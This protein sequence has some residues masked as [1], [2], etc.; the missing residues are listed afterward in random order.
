MR[1]GVAFWVWAIAAVTVQAVSVNDAFEKDWVQYSYGALKKTELLSHQHLL[2][3]STRNL[4]YFILASSRQV[5]AFVDLNLHDSNDF[6]ICG[7][8]IVTFSTQN[9]RLSLFDSSGIYISSIK[10]SAK[11][12]QIELHNDTLLILQQ[13][14]TLTAWNGYQVHDCGTYKASQLKLLPATDYTYFA[15]GS[16]TFR[17]R[18]YENK[19]EFSDLNQ[20]ESKSLFETEH[21][22][23]LINLPHRPLI[24]D[25]KYSVEVNL[26]GISL[27]ELGDKDKT[28]IYSDKLGSVSRLTTSGLAIVVSTPSSLIRYDLLKFASTGNQ[29]D[30]IKKEIQLTDLPDNFIF[31]STQLTESHVGSEIELRTHD[32]QTGSIISSLIPR[33]SFTSSGKAIIV[34][35]QPAVLEERIKQE[36]LMWNGLF[37]RLFIRYKN[38]LVALGRITSCLWNRKGCI[39][40]TVFH[41]DAGFEKLVIFIDDSS[42]DVVA[43]NSL[44]GAIHWTK[45]QTPKESLVGLI[46]VQEKVHVVY[47]HTVLTLSAVDGALLWTESV[48]DSIKKVFTIQQEDSQQEPGTSSIVLWT[49]KGLTFLQNSPKPE[50]PFYLATM[51]TNSITGH[52]VQNSTSRKTWTYAVE[53]GSIIA[54]SKNNDRLTVAGGIGRFDRSVLY[55][56]LDPNI[57]SVISEHTGG[58]KLT[59][60]N[61][62]T[63]E[64]IFQQTHTTDAIDPSS[65]K[66]IS[67]DN[68]VVYSYV[69][70]DLP[71]EQ[72]LVVVD[73][74]Q[75]EKFS[76]EQRSTFEQTTV[77]ASSASFIY[78]ERIHAL[79]ATDTL[80]GITIRSI[81]LL[82][83]SGSLVEVPK[84]VLNSRRKAR[85]DMTKNDYLDDFKMHPYEP[86]ILKTT[87]QV[88][89]H[90]HQLRLADGEQSILVQPTEYE[91][92]T[93]VCFTNELNQFCTIAQP[94]L[95]FD[96][97]ESGF[98]KLQLCATIVI[99]FVAYMFTVPLVY[100]KKLSALWSV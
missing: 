83:E 18:F 26:G 98:Q 4:L 53:H 91:S 45:T 63:G 79:A 61:G 66:L 52:Y 11:P 89:N 84:F 21:L 69:T 65:V 1:L 62:V 22:D 27:F 58:I 82:T 42:G 60:L 50:K 23:R 95:S 100:N 36:E 10:V 17:F 71:F 57:I 49:D 40:D 67:T 77:T 96:S 33:D 3:L 35:K 44:S 41:D 34:D 16:S 46:S 64:V 8:R 90:K 85:S 24:I 59:I 73:L 88:L 76:G 72:R 99:L 15:V 7:D 32:L 80:Y 55:K 30:V 47:T 28:A 6:Q 29:K 94:S 2:G 51:S 43:K 25:N 12:T 68:W 48:A 78:P 97:L 56:Y 81:I 37:H 39:N 13:D 87:K 70:L 54:A 9:S 14:G 93:V 31:T 5:D 74:F 20:L 75:T 86:V 19:G 92:S 38:H